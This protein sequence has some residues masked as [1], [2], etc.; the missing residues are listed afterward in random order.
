MRFYRYSLLTAFVASLAFGQEPPTPTNEQLT[1][2]V[3][4]GH[5]AVNVLDGRPAVKPLVEIRDKNGDPVSGANVTFELPRRNPRAAFDGNKNFT[6]VTAGSDGRAAPGEIRP[7][8]VGSFEIIIRAT[9]GKRTGGVTITQTNVATVSDVG[10]APPVQS[11]AQADASLKIEILDGDDGVNIIDKGTAVKPIV[12]IVDKNNLPVAGVAVAFA[13]IAT[14]GSK[15]EFPDGKNTITVTTGADGRAEAATLK[16][17]GKGSFQIQIQVN[18]DGQIV[19]RT[20]VQTN[21]PTEVAALDAG[22]MPGSSKGDSPTAGQPGNS[23]ATV[24]VVNGDNGVNFIK[25]NVGV[26][27]SVEVDDAAGLPVSGVQ[28]AF[29]LPSDGKLAL[30][31]NGNTYLIV[32][33]DGQ[34]QA[35][36]PHLHPVGKGVFSVKVLVAYRGVLLS[37]AI[38]QTNI[39]ASASA[40][41][42]PIKGGG[43]SAGKI[44]LAT[45]LVGG[46]AAIGIACATG[47]CQ[48]G[49]SSPSCSASSLRSQLQSQL[50]S[51]LPFCQNSGGASVQNSITSTWTQLCSCLGRGQNAVDSDLVAATLL[52]M[53]INVFQ[54]NGDTPAAIAARA[55][56]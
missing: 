55:C 5:K 50:Q 46:G 25:E 13:I 47:K 49:S 39:T 36:A 7:I 16:P 28:V 24:K 22:K 8:G 3:R 9:Q 32:T 34:G 35:V 18:S 42:P 40:P 43:G 29:I 2:V 53:C 14:R 1:V 52:V 38:P 10:I 33:T 48:K 12:R 37:A 27:P 20:I 21:Y 31:P 44:V 45:V 30:F 6:A 19:T 17:T 51:Y 15:T 41:N 56:N 11:A 4:E 54:P 23:T 26:S